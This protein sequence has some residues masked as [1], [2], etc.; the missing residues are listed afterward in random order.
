M[1][2]WTDS[3]A[4]NDSTSADVVQQGLQLIRSRMPNVYA[5]VQAKAAEIGPAAYA[6][7]RRGLRGQAR[8]FWAVEAGHVVG[9]PFDGHPVQAEVA[10]AMVQFGCAHVCVWG[11]PTTGGQAHGAA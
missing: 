10:R 4:R 11:E 8:C 5:A 3:G 6:L 9:T 7:V 2:T 1:D